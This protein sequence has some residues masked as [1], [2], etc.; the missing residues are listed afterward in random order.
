MRKHTN[1]NDAYF[2]KQTIFVNCYLLTNVHILS[3]FPNLKIDTLFT[4][5]NVSLKA[6]NHIPCIL[7]F[8]ELGH[9]ICMVYL[10]HKEEKRRCLNLKRHMVSDNVTL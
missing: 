2:Y 4:K 3:P 8:F 6:L 9:A 10:V 7:N 1:K 5:A